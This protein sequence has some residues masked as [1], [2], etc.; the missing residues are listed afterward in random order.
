MTWGGKGRRSAPEVAQSIAVELEELPKTIDEA[1]VIVA[2][3]MPD[4][5]PATSYA[6]ASELS[7]LSQ[8]ES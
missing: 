3:V 2:R 8:R 7:R 6:V 1:R 4:E 5:G